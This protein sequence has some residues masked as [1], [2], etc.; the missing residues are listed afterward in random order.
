MTRILNANL[1][2]F[3]GSK[4]ERVPK[5]LVVWAI[6]LF[7][8]RSSGL[9]LEITP[10]VLWLATI[11]ATVGGF[12]QVLSSEDTVNSLRGQ[13]MLPESP[14]QFHAAFYMAVAL[15][16]LL[17]K[18]GLL[19][20]G[21]LAVSDLRLSALVGF[22]VCFIVSG[23][24]TY[25]LVFRI[26]KRVSAYRY[27]NYRRHNFTVYLLRYLLNNKTY[28]GNTVVLWAFG[29]VF[30]A[31][32]G[33]SEFPNVLPLGFALMC[34]NTPLGILLS[35]DRDLYRQIKHLPR[36]SGGVLLPYALFITTVNVVAC[37]IYLMAW[38]FA[39]GSFAPIMIPV[40]LL[41]AVIS[42]G[43]SVWLEMK[44]PLLDWKVQSDLWHHPRKYV[45]PGFM[46]LLAL[47]IAI[48]TGGF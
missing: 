38:W 27:I 5:T 33:K 18:T 29:C 34:L 47:L 2:K 32:A 45:V 17:T 24:V 15:Y 30:A 23:L 41:F 8:L 13:L 39:V 35:S 44:Y 7:S 1:K 40:A 9:V 20:I 10:I 46:L 12:V 6:V 36:Q 28:L 16:T 19:L 43:L 31:I 14:T 21:Y 4:Y 37:G 48:L 22:F 11:V 25:P 26:E 3:M 42:A